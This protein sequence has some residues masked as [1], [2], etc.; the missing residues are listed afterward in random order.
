MT[1]KQRNNKNPTMSEP[2]HVADPCVFVFLLCV[3]R[4]ALNDSFSFGKVCWRIGQGLAT[5]V[6]ISPPRLWKNKTIRAFDKKSLIK[7][8]TDDQPLKFKKDST[9]TNQ[10]ETGTSCGP[11]ALFDRCF[12][13]HKRYSLGVFPRFLVH[14]NDSCWLQHW[15]WQNADIPS[16]RKRV[17]SEFLRSLL[18]FFL[19]SPSPPPNLPETPNF[20]RCKK[21]E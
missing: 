21:A 8:G 14:T 3:K 20:K 5:K 4:K 19:L 9:P 13:R 15:F 17:L 1:A 18:F 6:M 16:L 11:P 12:V 7:K 2:T 10:I